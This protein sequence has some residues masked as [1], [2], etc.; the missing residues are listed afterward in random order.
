MP[1]I[2][3]HWRLA[4]EALRHLPPEQPA[5]MGAPSLR[6]PACQP[7]DPGFNVPIVMYIGAIGPDLPYNAGITTRSAFFPTRQQRA[8]RGK[9]PW[10]DLMHYNKTGQFVIELLRHAPL[11]TSPDLRQKLYFYALGHATHI[12]ADIMMHPF[13]N[14]FAG[15]YHNQSNKA[16]YS[17]LGIHFGV[18]FCQDLATD[19]HYFHAKSQSMRPRPWLRYLVGA[20]EELLQPHAGMSL[21]DLIKETAQAVY[22][23]DSA[24]TEAFGN[25]M[26]A[27]LR[28]METLLSWFRYYPLVNPMLHIS[29]RL[30]TYFMEQETPG[31]KDT[32]LTFEQALG[33]ATQ[34]GTHLCGLLTTYF[35]DLMAGASD[36]GD[37]VGD[38]YTRLRQ[39]L[40]DWNLDTG[41]YL[42]QQWDPTGQQ[43]STITM[44][45]CWY[46]FL[47]LRSAL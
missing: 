45:H 28:G 37:S 24:M 35:S 32:A 25:N 17:G 4:I 41:Y 14:T 12:A 19:I 16:L 26:L 18:E 29:P 21:L 11:I 38:S 8:N 20:R 1:S 33:Y 43:V 9:S 3:T 36:D 42:D 31:V 13:I 44:R 40:R 30:S 22:A 2:L 34:V 5:L 27:G 10:A 23:L 6:L 47:P 7:T 46:H 15:A 39:D